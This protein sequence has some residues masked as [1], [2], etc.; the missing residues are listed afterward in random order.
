[1]ESE[2]REGGTVRSGFMHNL[3]VTIILTI[4]FSMLMRVNIPNFAAWVLIGLLVWRFFTVGTS[5]GL[6]SIISNPSLVT[7]LYMPRYLI[8]LSSSLAN[9][10]GAILEFAIFIP[11]L[12]FFGVVPGV[13]LLLLPVIILLEFLIIFGC[14][15]SLA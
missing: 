8:V 15:L 5:Q 12:I 11:L 3:D 1:M 14:S 10:L 6:S 13:V 2:R 9:L 4:V 7:K